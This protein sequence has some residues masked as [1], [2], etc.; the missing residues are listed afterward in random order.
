MGLLC[1]RLWLTPIIKVI[2]TILCKIGLLLLWAACW[3]TAAW[4]LKSLRSPVA[5]V[6]W[7]DR[8]HLHKPFRSL[9]QEPDSHT[10]HWILGPRTS[11]KVSGVCGWKIILGPLFPFKC[12]LQSKEFLLQLMS[13]L[14]Y[15]IAYV[16][17]HPDTCSVLSENLLSQMNN[18][19]RY[20]FYLPNCHAQYFFANWLLLCNMLPFF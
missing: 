3:V 19:I 11:F 15:F 18:F 5:Q 6:R 8:R 20:I 12:C 4:G 10:P 14:Q 2:P 16:Q 13:F 17:K 1:I 9:S 7:G